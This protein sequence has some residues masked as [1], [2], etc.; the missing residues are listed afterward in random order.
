MVCSIHSKHYSLTTS[1]KQFCSVFV[2]EE[3]KYGPNQ[4][5]F[6]VE[7]YQKATENLLFDDVIELEG[8]SY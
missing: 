5:E 7:T 3:H 8:S 6:K 2:A 4:V 1:S